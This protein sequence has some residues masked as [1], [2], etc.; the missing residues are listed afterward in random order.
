MLVPETDHPFPRKPFNARGSKV[1]RCD[2]C[3][4]P[5]S[6]CICAD[7][8]VAESAA[9]FWLLMHHNE[10]YKPSNTGRQI[11]Q[12]FPGSGVSE[13]QRLQ[14]QPEFETLLKQRKGSICLVFPEAPDYKHR[15]IKNTLELEGRP[16]FV[17]PDGTWRQ[18]RRIFRHSEYLQDL[19][20]IEPRVLEG[21]CYFLRN[22][23]PEHHLCTAEVAVALLAQ[24]GDDIGASALLHNF[25]LFNE[26]YY[27][28]KGRNLQTAA[29]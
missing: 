8:C 4:L 22:S 16:L 25:K 21:S 7:I 12:T 18:A 13:W 20:V 6:F 29:T 3:R 1:V 27:A 11:L 2:A 10:F 15:M 28:A 9:D 23:G 14:T 19:P 26:R 24:M 17:I 5:E